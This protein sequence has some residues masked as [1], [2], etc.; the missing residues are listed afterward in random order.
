MLAGWKPALP[1]AW[2]LESGRYGERA[3]T[4]VGGGCVYFLYEKST[5]RRVRRAPQ[6]SNN[7]HRTNGRC[8]L[9]KPRRLRNP[10]FPR[11]PTNHFPAPVPAF[12]GRTRA[13]RAGIHVRTRF[14]TTGRRGH[15]WS[16]TRVVEF[17]PRS[18][19]RVSSGFHDRKFKSGDSFVGHSDGAGDGGGIAVCR[20]GRFLGGAAGRGRGGD[21]GP[22]GIA[23]EPG[24][25][26]GTGVE[27]FDDGDGGATDRRK[28]SAGRG[29]GGGA[30]DFFGIWRI[31]N[32][33]HSE[34]P[35]CER[36]L[37]VDGGFAGDCGDGQRVCADCAGR[38]RRGAASVFEQCHFSRGGRCSGC[39]AAA[40]GF[41]HYQFD[42]G[43][44][45]HFWDW[46]VSETGRDG[47]GGGYVH[48]AKYRGVV[49]VLPAAAGD[50]THSDPCFAGSP[51]LSGDVSAG[52][53]FADG[54]SAICDCAYELDW[55]GADHQ[56]VWVGRAG[57]VH[58]CD[59]NFDFYFDAGVGIEQCGCD[60]GGTK[61]GGEATGAGGDF[62]LAN[63]VL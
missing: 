43:S 40:V 51:G 54:H 52:A 31:G 12:W 27:S 4:Q 6:G 29:G 28:R 41:E 61:P 45:L 25:C 57:W 39:N 1:L 60:A 62:R 37:A 13:E 3:P 10:R 17:N 14:A 53:R 2:P 23:A 24:V 5:S 16:S 58:D 59:S 11:F 20:G 9:R 30:G 46:A 19:S 38:K 26:G 34:L 32:R 50:G 44:M 49:S 42:S 48:G 36:S 8:P 15:R 63:R 56:R 22:Y 21:G 35:L 33:G 18:D 55:A 47:R 7:V